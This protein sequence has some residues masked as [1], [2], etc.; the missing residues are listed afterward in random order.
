MVCQDRFDRE[1]IELKQLAAAPRHRPELGRRRAYRRCVPGRDRRAHDESAGSRGDRRCVRDV[2]E[3]GVTDEHGLSLHHLIRTKTDRPRAWA[4]VEPDV[5]Q[6]DLPPMHEFE[7][8]AA[9][10]PK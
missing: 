7:A 10:P 6:I 4:P 8:G 5:E 9:E 3:M 1:A 2:I